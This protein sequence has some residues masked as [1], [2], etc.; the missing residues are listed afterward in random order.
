MKTYTLITLAFV[1]AFTI[2]RAEAGRLLPEDSIGKDYWQGLDPKSKMVFLTAY[3]HTQ[4]PVEDQTVRPE[5][6]RLNT[7]H[8]PALVAKLNEFYNVPVNEHVFLSA[9]IRI[10]FMEISGKSKADIDKATKQAQ[11]VFSKL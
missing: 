10:C 5:F 8:F 3:R 4:G 1:C 2:F 6:R 9:A 11:E 7:G